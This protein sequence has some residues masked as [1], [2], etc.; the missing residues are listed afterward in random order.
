MA[1]RVKP[2]RNPLHRDQIVFDFFKGEA[3]PLVKKTRLRAERRHRR[4]IARKLSDWFDTRCD[5]IPDVIAM[6]LDALIKTRIA[7]VQSKWTPIEEAERQGI[8]CD[9]MLDVVESHDGRY[10]EPSIHRVT[11]DAMPYLYDYD[12]QQELGEPVFR[13]VPIKKKRRSKHRRK[14]RRNDDF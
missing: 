3:I 13:T 4:R 2:R 10:F 6:K 8:N 5:L 12:D 11:R 7:E 14:R 1:L 9:R